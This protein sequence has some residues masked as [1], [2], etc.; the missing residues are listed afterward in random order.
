[1]AFVSTK[2][3]ISALTGCALVSPRI[4]PGNRRRLVQLH[5]RL[6]WPVRITQCSTG[7]QNQVGLLLPQNLL[8]LFCRRD[9]PYSTGQDSRLLAHLFGKGHLKA[10]R[11]RDRSVRDRAARGAIDQIHSERLHLTRSKCS[12]DI[13]N[14]AQSHGSR[15]RFSTQSFDVRRSELMR[16]DIQLRRPLST[17]RKLSAH[18]HR[19][20]LP[21][22]IT[23]EEHFVTESF[24]RATG[25]RDRETPPQLAEL[26]PK[27][28]DLGAGRYPDS[29]RQPCRGVWLWALSGDPL[30]LYPKYPG[31]D[32][33]G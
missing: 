13:R 19:P 32:G 30:A 33:L 29:S 16:I 4:L 9:Q 25:A 20:N 24:L 22:T 21:R 11:S 14:A 10:W 7:H 6:H 31:V 15:E 2:L 23:L 17:G 5:G 3:K 27:L 28:L 8:R 26:Q 1:V 18:W 12:L